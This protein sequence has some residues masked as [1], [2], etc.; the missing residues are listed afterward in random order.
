M[1][2]QIADRARA[3]GL[4]RA[5]R[6]AG[7]WQDVRPCFEAFDLFLSPSRT[8]GLSNVLLEAMAFRLPVVATRVGGNAEIIEDRVSGILVD[9]EQPRAL[10][11]AL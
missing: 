1:G 9:P 8:E 2:Q 11:G 4:E 10:A 7:Y 6:M 5:V 3:L